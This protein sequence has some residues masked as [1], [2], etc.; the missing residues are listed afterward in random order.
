MKGNSLSSYPPGAKIP[1]C[2][3]C[4]KEKKKTQRICSTCFDKVMKFQV[5]LHCPVCVKVFS[6]TSSRL[7]QRLS[8][9][10]EQ[11]CCSHQCAGKARVIL[12]KKTCLQCSKLF[13][14]THRSAQCCSRTCAN[15]LHSGRMS[16]EGNSR[17]SHGCEVGNFKKL[18]PMIL[19]RDNFSC[20][21]CG[22][23][24]R[25]Q[26]LSNDMIR[27]NLCVHHIDHNRATN[28][29]QNLITLCRQ[30]HVA[31]HQITDKA[32]R[33]SPFPELQTLATER[34]KSMILK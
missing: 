25:K 15:L 33:L 24:E 18:R 34:S 32:G 12:I 3:A 30:C 4:G 9:N 16:G 2:L 1:Q 8:K 7:A 23:K 6:L 31:H 21:G 11:I 19:E 20:V 13:Q 29:L 27:T 28:T 5:R 22:T 10:P 17:Y 26:L 14:P